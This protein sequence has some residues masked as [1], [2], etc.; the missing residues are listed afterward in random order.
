MA[1][2][3]WFTLLGFTA[4]TGAIWWAVFAVQGHVGTLLFIA[5]DVGQ[6]DSLFFESPFGTQI[7]VDGG[8]DDA[9]LEKL[10]SVM[11]FWDRSLDVVLLT[12]PDAD[13]ITGLVEVLKR[14][15][16]GLV[17]ETGVLHT[18]GVYE[19]WL[20]VLERKNIPIAYVAE[21]DELII[22]EHTRLSVLSPLTSPKGK[23]I[24]KTNNT[25]IIA[26]LV[27]NDVSF[28][29]TGDAEQDVEKILAVLSEDALDADVLKVGHHGS[30]TSTSADLLAAVTPDVAV[31]SLG[32]RNT[33]GH[34][35]PEVIA[36]L[37]EWQV[38]I[39]RT[40]IQGDIRLRSDGENIWP[41]DR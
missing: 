20:R 33:Y 12:H 10:G 18:S 2:W 30:K 5:F 22:D 24:P 7:L 11:P 6:G 9:V 19:E 16:V 28:L 21:G 4:L 37:E 32:K 14:Y 1:R 41:A 25:S 8:P 31:I 13:H 15:D 34:P 29:L 40:D 38:P 3:K 23:E 27:Y 26:R 36:R 39:L 35:H 17:V